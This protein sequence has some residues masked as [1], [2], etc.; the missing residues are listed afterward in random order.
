MVEHHYCETYYKEIRRLLRIIT[1]L[2]EERDG[3][4]NTAA[5]AEAELAGRFS[6]VERLRAKV[7]AHEQACLL[8]WGCPRQNESERLRD[9]LRRWV[10]AWETSSSTNLDDR[11]SELCKETR[12]AL[13]KEES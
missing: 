13:A 2:T 7:K 10:G 8:G 6:E 3:W 9:I 5:A 11:L 1:D 4:M 12:V